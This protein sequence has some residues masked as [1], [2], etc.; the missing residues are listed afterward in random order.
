MTVCSGFTEAVTRI[1]ATKLLA[2]CGDSTASCWLLTAELRRFNLAIAQWAWY[3]MCE[4]S[5][6]AL[7]RVFGSS[8][9]ETDVMSVSSLGV[10]NSTVNPG[11][12]LQHQCVVDSASNVWLIGQS[13]VWL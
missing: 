1:K 5:S 4:C 9:P 10:A 12:R 3:R 8:V 13:L 11:T 7:C 6:S 2:I